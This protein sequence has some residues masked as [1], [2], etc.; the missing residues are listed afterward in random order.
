MKHTQN[1][2]TATHYLDLLI[3]MHIYITSQKSHRIIIHQFKTQNMDPLE[4][5]NP[6][7][8]IQPVVNPVVQPVWQPA[9]SCK[10][11]S[12][13]LS[14][15]LSNGFDNRFDNPVERTALFVQP[16]VKPGWTTVLTT[17]CIHDAAVCQTDLTTGLTTGLTTSCIVYT[18]I[19]PSCQTTTGLTTGLTTGCIV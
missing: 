1:L 12:N 4:I 8:T 16:V 19:L 6:V 7:Y 14:Y 13:R 5:S 15:R 10:Q 3:L 17:G 2:C 11:T 18:N 9:V